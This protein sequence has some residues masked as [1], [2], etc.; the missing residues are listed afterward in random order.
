MGARHVNPETL[1]G[2]RPLGTLETNRLIE[3]GFIA[4]P[5]KAP[6]PPTEHPLATFL[7]RHFKAGSNW[8]T[9]DKAWDIANEL[10]RLHAIEQAAKRA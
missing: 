7:Y 2:N 4:D 10:D 1:L 6:P 5:N 3:R 8:L 9:K